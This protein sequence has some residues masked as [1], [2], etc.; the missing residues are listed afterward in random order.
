MVCF[1]VKWSFVLL[2]SL[3]S[4]VCG[5][6]QTAYQ[7]IEKV[8]PDF[9]LLIARAAIAEDEWRKWKDKCIEQREQL[10]QQRKEL[11]EQADRFAKQQQLNQQHVA[12]LTARQQIID[13]LQAELA[14][15]R[16]QPAV[17]VAGGGDSAAVVQQVYDKL[18]ADM[19]A[20][21]RAEQQQKEE[22][23]MELGGLKYQLQQLTQENVQLKQQLQASMSGEDR[24]AATPVHQVSD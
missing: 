11:K 12:E 19:K 1:S 18:L 14:E 24:C 8:A 2:V 7:H 10:K 6:L 13:S 3:T 20:E 21:M 9:R 23:I 22:R 4:C 15:I 17:A 16:Q 5:L